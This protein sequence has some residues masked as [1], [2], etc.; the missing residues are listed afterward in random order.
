MYVPA[1]A[2]ARRFFTTKEQALSWIGAA[3]QSVLATA[4]FLSGFAGDADGAVAKRADDLIFGQDTRW[5]GMLNRAE[6]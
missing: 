4:A 6:R 5:A 2:R 3:C 1:K